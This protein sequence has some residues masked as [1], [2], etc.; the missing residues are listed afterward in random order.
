MTV[1]ILPAR[2]RRAR[3]DFEETRFAEPQD[4]A[5]KTKVDKATAFMVWIGGLFVSLAIIA[6]LARL[7]GY[8]FH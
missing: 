5:I 7:A 4:P 6:A 2:S 3:P 1:H 8:F